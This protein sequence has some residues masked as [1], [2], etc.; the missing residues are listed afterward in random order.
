[1]G[2]T[3]PIADMLTRIRNA[4]KAKLG[5]VDMPASRLK[6]EMAKILKTEG[7]IKH[8]K[9]IN[10]QKQGIL[11]LYL[12]PYVNQ[13]LAPILGLKRISKPSRRTYLKNKE[14]KPVL[15]GMGTAI[16]STSK[17][18]L[19]DKQAREINVGGEILCEIW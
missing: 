7:Y 18:L 8:Y 1:M 11:R 9:A 12:K 16:I 6:T 4:T 14:I 17:G 19:T 2:M 13:A 10:D 3:D 5:K 15:N